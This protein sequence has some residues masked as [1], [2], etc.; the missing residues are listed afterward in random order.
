[1]KVVFNGLL[2]KRS[3][4]CNCKKHGNSEYGYVSQK[5]Y[6]LPSGITKTFVVGKPEEVS[7]SDGNFLLQYKYPDANGAYREIFSKVD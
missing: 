1:M 6:I 5:M 3:K 7:P 2:E 4:G